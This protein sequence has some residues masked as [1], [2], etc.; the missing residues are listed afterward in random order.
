MEQFFDH[1][2]PPAPR[3]SEDGGSRLSFLIVMALLIAGGLGAYNYI[4]VAYEAAEFKTE[5]QKAVDGAGAMGRTSDWVTNEI[6]RNYQTYN[7]PE[8]AD[9]K[10]DRLAKGGYRA[11]VKYIKPIKVLGFAYDYSFDKTVTTSG[12]LVE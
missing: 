2:C 12:F 5:M 7:V 4:P 8:G 10:V 3:R 6:A 9:L 11:T 1:G